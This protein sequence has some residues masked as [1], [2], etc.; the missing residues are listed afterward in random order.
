MRQQATY[1]AIPFVVGDWIEPVRRDLTTFR[2]MWSR[3]RVLLVAPIIILAARSAV[4]AVS[5]IILAGLYLAYQ[6]VWSKLTRQNPRLE[7]A[8]WSRLARNV[9]AVAASLGLM[10]AGSLSGETPPAAWVLLLTVMLSVGSE[11]ERTYARALIL[12]TAVA[13]CGVDVLGQPGW[14]RK[15]W[16]DALAALGDALLPGLVILLA[17][18]TSYFYSRS[19]AYLQRLHEQLATQA[20]PELV[21][22]ADSEALLNRIVTKMRS[23]FQDPRDTLVV[24][25]LLAEPDGRLRLAASSSPGGQALAQQGYRFARTEGITGWVWRHGQACIV[26]DT[27]RDPERR[28]LRHPA[29]PDTVCEMAAPV[30]E[31]GAVTMVLDVESARRDTF[32]HEDLLALQVVASVVAQVQQQRRLMELHQRLAAL[33]RDLA[34]RVITTRDLEPMFKQVA[35]AAMEFLGADLVSFYVQDPFRNELRGPYKY[36]ALRVDRPSRDPA[37]LPEDSL[38]HRIIRAGQLRWYAN[39]QEESDL[40]HRDAYHR[41]TGRSVFVEREGIRSCAAVPLIIGQDRLGLMFINYRHERSLTPELNAAIELFGGLAAQA[42][43]AGL[44]DEAQ[45]AWRHRQLVEAL[46]DSIRHHLLS[47]R[48]A[49][50][51]LAGHPARSPEWQDAFVSAGFFITTGCRMADD[52]AA[53]RNSCSVQGLVDDLY[54]RAWCIDKAYDIRIERDFDPLELKGWADLVIPSGNSLLYVIDQALWNALRHARASELRLHVAVTDR[55]LRVEI[56]D[57]GCGFEVHQVPAASRGLINMRQ[58]VEQ[59]MG[60]KLEIDAAPGRGTRI[61]AVVPVHLDQKASE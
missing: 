36:G 26:P 24:N 19:I 54:H 10:V 46:H 14:E 45:A 15:P 7:S 4:G 34:Q 61:V 22:V 25:V 16:Y 53:G 51:K 17:G 30:L 40:T 41:Q 50:E 49:L 43:Q 28:F 13:V 6:F 47:A 60:G 8:F 32:N 20:L 57:N 42:I 31:D 18:L 11:L 3:W 56:A 2:R 21:S 44:H 58:R 52:L 35:E 23:L 1:G 12:I 38:V 48:V 59:H 5:A 9:G 39:A 33:T 55:E 37:T 27:D 29:F